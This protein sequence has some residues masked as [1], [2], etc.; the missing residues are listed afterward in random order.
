MI[1]INLNIILN[2]IFKELE[3]SKLKGDNKYFVI[4]EELYC[5]DEKIYDL[6]NLI[7]VKVNEKGV[8]LKFKEQ[9]SLVIRKD[10]F[11]EIDMGGLGLNCPV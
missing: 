10:M 4:S 9:N 6:S 2:N 8:I 3:K 5:N 11:M 1:K 7:E